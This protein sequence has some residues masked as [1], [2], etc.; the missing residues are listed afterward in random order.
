M[1]VLNESIKYLRAQG[2]IISQDVEFA[3]DRTNGYF[4]R[5]KKNIHEDTVLLQVP[6]DACLVPG[7]LNT[8][9][10]SELRKQGCP[11]VFLS[12]I[13]LL[14]DYS[15]HLQKKGSVLSSHH[16]LIQ[17]L[18]ENDNIVYWTD[19]EKQL[20]QSTILEASLESIQ[21]G[22]FFDDVIAPWYEKHAKEW[23]PE[24]LIKDQFLKA[25]SA[26][27]S[28]AYTNEQFIPSTDK[29]QEYGHHFIP[30]ADL[31]NHDASNP[32]A[33]IVFDGNFFSF[34]STSSIDADQQVY[35][36]YGPLGNSQLFENYGFVQLP[37]DG[38]MDHEEA[39]NED[40]EQEDEGMDEMGARI[41][42]WNPNNCIHISSDL[43]LRTVKSSL[44]NRVKELAEEEKEKK[45]GKK[46]A[47][48]SKPWTKNHEKLFQEA[49]K[50]LETTR[51]LTPS[52]FILSQQ[53][54]ESTDGDDENQGD[55]STPD[56]VSDGAT[57]K[58]DD[59][60]SN[61][62]SA[63]ENTSPSSFC[64]SLLPPD[65]LTVVQVLCMILDPQSFDMYK[66]ECNDG[67][68]QCLL[69]LDTMIANTV[70]TWANFE[71]GRHELEDSEV[72]DEIEDI[73]QEIEHHIFIWTCIQD[74]LSAKLASYPTS[75]G[76]DHS[77]WRAYSMVKKGTD[78]KAA[79]NSIFGFSDEADEEVDGE[80]DVGSKRKRDDDS[81]PSKRA[82]GDEPTNVDVTNLPLLSQLE[83]SINDKKYEACRIISLG[84]K[85]LLSALLDDIRAD[86]EFAANWSPDDMDDSDGSESF[87]EA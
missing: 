4:V 1:D 62:G 75:R 53:A 69:T 13:Q 50:L 76:Y 40:G 8:D 42:G 35:I 84:E 72:E 2:V 12:A 87:E 14:G 19:R 54:Q 77:W 45:K 82:R 70:E 79:I 26:V 49:V 80:F 61:I 34:V 5:A 63:E 32:T 28:R 17:S 64:L 68:Y 81:A 52:G 9:F 66:K 46:K 33:S 73:E 83:L 58:D 3:H 25:L 47:G 51:V 16:D 44:M 78:P 85:E 71:M 29:D 39:G 18:P 11:Q 15:K 37:R 23:A 30:L 20:L 6:V 7:D 24:A 86:E 48:K 67:E 22:T 43:V 59:A 36:S 57:K 27:L 60:E 65:L 56:Q 55:D 10:Y 31:F 21:P 38:P 41:V 74:I